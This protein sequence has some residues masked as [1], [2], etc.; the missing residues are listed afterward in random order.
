MTAFEY[1]FLMNFALKCSISTNSIYG[2]DDLNDVNEVHEVFYKKN[3]YKT[4]T[5]FKEYN[6]PSYSGSSSSSS[7]SSASGY[8]SYPSQSSP[9]SKVSS[10]NSGQPVHLAPYGQETRQTCSP[11][12][13]TILN[14]ST[15]CTQGTS[16]CMVQCL[17]NYQLPNGETMAR[18]ICNNGEWVLEKLDWTD[19]LACERMSF[20]SL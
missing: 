9:Y 7:S 13:K 3:A 2:K 20:F 4:G 6:S 12:P 18:M 14:A 8:G 19:K 5:G 10:Y 11:K 15:R 17:E 16:T 1:I